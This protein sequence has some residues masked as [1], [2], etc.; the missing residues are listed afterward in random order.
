[1]TVRNLDLAFRPR[2]VA[3]LG[4]SDEAGSVGHFVMQN[5]IGGGFEGSV[6][7]INPHHTEVAGLRCYRD[8]EGLPDAP[9]LAV[10]LTPAKTVPEIISELGRKG[11]K[12]AVVIGAGLTSENGLRQKM[13]DAAKPHLLRIIGPNT[14]GLLV[15]PLKLN[16]SFAHMDARPGSIALLSQSGA[17]AT[18]LIDWAAERDI[19]FSHIVSLGDMADVD[20]ADCLDLLAGDGRTRAILMY[21][22]SVP[23]ARK[24]LTAAR[25]ASRLKPVI[26]LK[27]GRSPQAAKAAATHTGALSGGDDVVDAALRRCGVLRV[28]GLAEMFDAAETV[29]RFRPLDRA[30][31]GIVTNGGGAGVLAVDRLAEGRGELAE[32]DSTTIRSLAERLPANWS[33]ANPVD[34]IGD[35]PATRYLGAVHAVAADRDVDVVLVMNCP[36][37]LASPA[38]AARAVA[39]EVRKGMIGRKPVLSCWLGGATARDARRILREAGVASYDTPATAA[40][41]VGHLTDWGRAQEALLRMPDRVVED[42]LR[43]TPANAR[44]VARATFAAVAAEGR[45]MLTEPEAKSVLA[46]YGIPVPETRVAVTA[47]DAGDLASDLLR[48][49]GRLAVKLL[50]RDISHKSDVGGVVLDVATPNEAE[51]AALAIEARVRAA[52]PEASI[53]GFALQPMVEREASHELIL[54]VTRD[55]VFG[56]VLLFGAGGVS[57]EIVRDTAI[58]LPPLDPTLASDLVSRTR[59][60]RL[61]AGYRDRP[62]ADPAAID[63]A[64]IALSH[65]IE[66]FPCLRGVDV[67]PLLANAEGVIALDARIEIDPEDMERKGPNPDLAIR[68]YPSEWRSVLSLDDGAWTLRPIRPADA[69]LYATF[70]EHVDPED[71]RLRFLAPRRHFPDRM[72]VR[73]TQLDYDRDMAFVALTPSGELAGVARLSCDPDRTLGEYAVLIRSDLHG[74]G[75]GRALMEQLIAWARAE[76]IKRVESMILVENTGMQRLAGSLGMTLLPDPEDPGVIQSHLTL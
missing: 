59:I 30:R 4:A 48:Q 26:A 10:I 16:A 64:L 3:V 57:V 14:L 68:P 41:A 67:N 44:E 55:P 21:L 22:E 70:F 11:C 9:D 5:L 50:S 51:E 43:K 23:N 54:G 65:L 15:P 2:S 37:A 56:P 39:G 46:A 76:G 7:P 12:A 40:A 38:D 31:L 8:A 73:L 71:I 72:I 32:L 58:A 34:I 25:A 20:V 63:G 62:A 60:G 1:M 53:D 66:D 18:T 19:G 45:A 28:R 47:M 13:L 75:L 24:F 17:I 33:R 35:A 27:A 52:A 29:S 61:L 49:G 74:R 69:S 6:W 36:T 42:T